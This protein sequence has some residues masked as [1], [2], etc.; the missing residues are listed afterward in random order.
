V[1]TVKISYKYNFLVLGGFIDLMTGGAWPDHLTLT[2]Q[3]VMR[4]ENQETVTP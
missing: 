4:D 1:D 3:T 2:A